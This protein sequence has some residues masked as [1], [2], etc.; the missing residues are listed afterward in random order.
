MIEVKNLHKYFNKNRTNQIHVINNTSI[1][2]PEKGLVAITG[3]SGCGKTTLL[4]VV[5]GLDSFHSGEII[6]EGESVK[7][8]KS[9]KVDYI[10]NEK[11]GFIFQNYHLL[12]DQSVYDNIKTSLN[13]A[14]LYDKEQLDERIHYSLEK[15]GMFNY[16]KRNVLALSGGQQQR[17]GIARAI[18]K[19]PDVIFADEPTGNLDS[20]NTFEVMSLIKNISKNKLVILV[21]HER[22]LVDLFADRIIEL[23]DG[24]VTND[25]QNFKNTTYQHKDDRFIYLKDLNKEDLETKF[26]EYYYE[27]ENNKHFDF[28]VVEMNDTIYIQTNSE[29]KIQ[30]IDHESEI[31]LVDEH[32]KE[33]K[34]EEMEILDFENFKPIEHH[35]HKSLFRWRDTLFTGFKKLF[36]K[37]KFGRKILVFVYFV[38]SAVIAFQLAALGNLI[39]IN[40]YEF[41]SSPKSFVAIENTS[42]LTSSDY[43]E[44]MEIDG[45]GS[46]ILYEGQYYSEYVSFYQQSF[47]QTSLSVNLSVWPVK[48]SWVDEGDLLVGKLPVE[49]NEVAISS[50]TA[51][52]ILNNYRVTQMGYEDA[53]DLLDF[54]VLSNYYRNNQKTNLNVVG[55]VESTERLIIYPDNY[56]GLSMEEADYYSILEAYEEDIDIVNGRMPENDTEILAI[57]DYFY[58]INEQIQFGTGLLKVVGLYELK[59]DSGLP[60]TNFLLTEKALELVVVQNGSSYR[61]IGYQFHADDKE[62]VINALEDL[63]YEAYDLYEHDKAIYL[64]NRNFNISAS[65]SSMIAIFVGIV[66]FIYFLMRTSMINRVKEIGIYRAIGATKKDVYKIFI[67]EIL[68]YTTFL[69]ATGYLIAAYL[70]TTI[71]NAI[72]SYYPVFYL[73]FWLLMIGLIGIYLINIVFGLLPIFNLLRKSPAEILAKYDI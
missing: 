8:Y 71:E 48:S 26:I 49:L 3:P 45:I 40:E 54:S 17:V 5:A 9:S 33:F 52:M 21:T 43:E 2:F 25:Y 53:A 68:I 65:I 56:Y 6:Y 66:L 20:N 51:D 13:I 15:V 18:A 41:L 38:I 16:R 64:E 23:K 22:H 24:L 69:S 1:Q 61:Q 7:K 12:P 73:P 60:R 14:G 63:G 62:S 70:L 47:Y 28:K 67:S 35:L 19:N 59:E 46:P 50:F 55:I 11:I 4:N 32:K 30:F 34:T 42:K 58:V 39:R 29:K 72:G 36:T 37:R 31:S 57:D 44:I 10:R 27:K